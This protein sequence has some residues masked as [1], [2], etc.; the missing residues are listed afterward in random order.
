M[1]MFEL[2]F[3]TLHQ[4]LPALLVMLG[5]LLLAMVFY[6]SI[7]FLVEG[8]T[9]IVN[10]DFP[11]GAFVRRASNGNSFEIS[12]FKSVPT[13][14]YWLVTTITTGTIRLLLMF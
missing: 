1:L 11:Q 8:G 4:S 2:I 9:Y 3:A 13:S 10:S 5:V 7:I 14:F 12:P 6:G